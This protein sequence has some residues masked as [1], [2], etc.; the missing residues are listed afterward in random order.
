MPEKP[1]TE[2]AA[3]ARPKRSGA[4]NNT[5]RQAP[6]PSVAER[7]R[8]SGG[9]GMT[10]DT[11]A[12]LGGNARGV[13][14]GINNAVIDV[15]DLPVKGL[16]AVGHASEWAA[17]AADQAATR[18]G[19]DRK[20]SY[21]GNRFQPGTAVM[22]LAE[23]FPFGL[24]GSAAVSA[25]QATQRAGRAARSATAAA[26]PVVR[27]ILADTAG[28]VSIPPRQPR[29]GALSPKPKAAPVAASEFRQPDLG[30]V[31]GK[32]NWAILTGENPNGKSIPAAENLER[33]ERLLREAREMGIEP[34]P[35]RGHYGSNPENSYLL[36]PIDQQ[37][38][39]QLGGRY[40]Q[41]SV[42]TNQGLLYHDGTKTPA[43]GASYFNEAPEDFYSVIDTPDGP[44]NFA[45][46]LKWGDDG[47]M[48]RIPDETRSPGDYPDPRSTALGSRQ[49]PFDRGAAHVYDN[50]GLQARLAELG[51][52]EAQTTASLPN[53]GILSPD[54]PP[55]G[56]YDNSNLI[57][58]RRPNNDKKGKNYARYGNP[59]EEIL[60]QTGQALKETPGAFKKNTEMLAEE[61]F[62]QGV[63]GS[64]DEVYDQAVRR[65]ADNLKYITEELMDPKLVQDARPWYETAHHM[66][67][68][69]AK[70]YGVPPEAAWA[71]NAVMSPQKPWPIN[72]ANQQRMLE[73]NANGYDVGSAGAQKAQ[74]WVNDRLE[75]DSPGA[76]AVKGP[77][78]AARI[79]ATPMDEL[80]DAADRYAK[81]VLTDAVN[82]NR[83]VP[84]VLPDGS[85]GDDYGPIT[86]GS[87]RE[88]NSGLDIL[89]NPSM[90]N[91]AA[92]MSGG[93]KV[94]SFHN[95]QANPWSDK[96]IVTADTHSAGALSLFPGGGSDPIVYRTMGLSGKKGLP[97]AAASS[98]STGAKG[99]YGWATDAHVL[100]GKELG[101]QPREVQSVTWEGVRGAWGQ[102]GKT[103]ALKKAI[104]DAWRNASSPDEA[105]AAI[106]GILSS[107]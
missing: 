79:M 85:F 52:P 27:D 88:V 41:D 18:S 99:L 92:N 101:M 103:P 57:S 9:L 55:V 17:R 83:M 14:G 51:T 7:I 90:E 16:E 32:D 70:Q 19:L 78:Y 84:N 62:M 69:F 58:T 25:G 8:R 48:V 46:D 13:L 50:E 43:T 94:P 105:R 75:T 64:T 34:V 71:V 74:K 3:P 38:A 66:G 104:A 11:R 95:N 26:K 49:E 56:V 37:Q 40:E 45:V 72:V 42:L 20:L 60:I 100:A 5:P 29:K 53:M 2:R 86:W 67:Q 76:V 82:N 102:S 106:K 33:N 15:L 54:R 81:V 89:D 107:R 77:E 22:G 4:L 36:S 39:L 21:D 28:E 10:K 12:W 98:A 68:G 35:V 24:D 47:E 31:M 91:I 23:A 6:N 65:G 97:K 44:A 73:M 1:R 30:P 96:P 93:G 59:D 80:T 61:P 87:A 63:T